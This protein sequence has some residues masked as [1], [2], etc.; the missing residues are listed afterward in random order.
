MGGA[1]EIV[2]KKEVRKARQTAGT[3]AP[4]A[5]VTIRDPGRQPSLAILP[6]DGEVRGF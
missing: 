1:P 4:G 6:T 5:C 2:G 3:L